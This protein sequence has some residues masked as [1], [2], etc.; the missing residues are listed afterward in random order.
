MPEIQRSEATN[1]LVAEYE[2]LE[3]LITSL[4]RDD[5]I[6]PSGCRDWTNADLIF[7]LLLDAQRALV[8]FNSPAKGPSDKDFVTY[9]E[10]FLASDESAQAHARFVRMS[11]AAH[12]DPGKLASRWRETAQA[13][14]R[15][16]RTTSN[17]E[18]VATQGHVLRTADFVA[19]LVVEATIHHLDLVANLTREENPA[20]TAL[21]ITTRTLDGLLSQHR[22][23][24]WG[25]TEY[26]LKAT[27]RQGFTEDERRVLGDAM[28]LFPLFS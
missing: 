26:I 16:A 15:C 14:T 19:T 20:P 8:T 17:I 10:G 18:F 11:T 12:S 22:R 2:V 4:T 27:G 28:Q 24:S 23:P 13:A 7:H 9:W 5:L 21:A 3:S 25:G 6:A 1:A